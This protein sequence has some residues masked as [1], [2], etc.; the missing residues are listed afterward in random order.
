MKDHLPEFETFPLAPRRGVD[1]NKF[2]FLKNMPLNAHVHF[3]DDPKILRTVVTVFNDQAKRE[4]SNFHLSLR[5]VGK[6]IQKASV[7]AS[8][9]MISGSTVRQ[10]SQDWSPRPSHGILA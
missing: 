3:T 1:I 7:F 2:E 4:G 9:V 10:P 6:A 5:R 8:F